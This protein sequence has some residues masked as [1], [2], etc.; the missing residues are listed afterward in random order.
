M[1][2][3]LETIFFNEFF[4]LIGYTQL[5]GKLSYEIYS[6]KFKDKKIPGID[7]MC[8]WSHWVLCKHYGMIEKL[9]L[10]R[11]YREFDKP[12]QPVMYEAIE[13]S[14]FDGLM[15]LLSAYVSFT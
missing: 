4:L 6:F 7:C 8:L 2:Q 9:C 14:S 15:L 5:Q 10:T 11:D 12:A 1:N 13:S 3:I